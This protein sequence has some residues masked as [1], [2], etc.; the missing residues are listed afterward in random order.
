MSVRQLVGGTRAPWRDVS[1]YFPVALR[2]FLAPHTHTLKRAGALF[3]SHSA[4][5]NITALGTDFV[6]C[7]SETLFTTLLN[8]SPSFPVT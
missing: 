7:T 3:W 1:D 6:V 8:H 5:A 4:F 2:F